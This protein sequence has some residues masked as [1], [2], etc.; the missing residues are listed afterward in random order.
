[1]KESKFRHPEVGGVAT[2]AQP[3]RTPILEASRS[4]DRTLRLFGTGLELDDSVIDEH[5]AD[6]HERAGPEP[7]EGTALEADLGE[8]DR[9]EDQLQAEQGEQVDDPDRT[10]YPNR[11]GSE[12]RH[13]Q[14]P[15]HS[16]TE[17]RHE[18]R[19]ERSRGGERG[20][21]HERDSPGVPVARDLPEAAGADEERDG[22]GDVEQGAV[23]LGEYEAVGPDLG[24]PP[25]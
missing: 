18:P 8:H 3:D 14:Q 21:E 2:A 7:R 1:M 9:G 22:A 24:R 13:D 12:R 4:I 15:L 11:A 16:Y 25:C 5:D 20:P 6:E 10:D 17:S 23:G 19:P